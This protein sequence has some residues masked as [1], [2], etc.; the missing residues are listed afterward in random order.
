MNMKNLIL[1]PLLLFLPAP[2]PAVDLYTA[3]VPVADESPEARSGAMQGALRQVL[4]KV[5]GQRIPAEKLDGVL[6]KAEDQVQEFRYQLG[7]A[8]DAAGEP[9]KQLWVRFDRNTIARIL[10]RVGMSAWEGGRPE[11][12]L[13]L[14]VDDGQR[15]LADP[16]QDAS[17]L[18][19]A[20]REAEKR[21]FTLVVPLMDLQDRNSLAAADLWM[22]N[23]QGIQR[24]S[25]RYGQA[26]PLA[27]RLYRRGDRWK[28]EWSLLL[29]DAE[30]QFDR[31]ATT[32]E[33]AIQR[34][35][36]RA[37]ELLAKQ[38]APAAP[39]NGASVVD[40]R[41]LGVEDLSRFAWLQRRLESL[42]GVSL[43]TP[44][45]LEEDQLVFRVRIRGGRTALQNQLSLE[46]ALVPAVDIPEGGGDSAAV[47]LSY[48]V[49]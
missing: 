41:F 1:L 32:P 18:E 16:E 44:L 8:T 15:R 31:S 33:G 17:L 29:P 3:T 38:Y 47:S 7:P 20:R 23:V 45:M 49:R 10:R 28:G 19:V 46:P 40:L 25:A 22:G 14:A 4:E 13:W 12:I 24:A 9:L 36:R 37:G 42:D 5:S 35:L 6:R 11:L 2:L 34:A 30:R 48:S 26:V 43:V 21:G 27:G 39:A